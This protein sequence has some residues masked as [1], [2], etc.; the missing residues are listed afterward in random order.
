MVTLCFGDH[1]SDVHVYT[2][3]H[4]RIE[5]ILSKLCMTIVTFV[6]L[7]KW[8][9]FVHTNSDNMYTFCCSYSWEKLVCGMFYIYTCFMLHTS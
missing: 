1:A 3:G 5:R 2:E 7:A 8:M 9:N 4:R 6:L